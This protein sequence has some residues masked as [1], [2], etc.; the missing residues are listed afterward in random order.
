[1]EQAWQGAGA[2]SELDLV[3]W[4]DEIVGVLQD[5]EMLIA[6]DSLETMDTDACCFDIHKS[7][8]SAFRLV[9]ETEQP[10]VERAGKEMHPREM[11][12]EFA[13]ADLLMSAE[14]I[15]PNRETEK[16]N[17]LCVHKPLHIVHELLLMGDMLDDVAQ[18]D[19]VEFTQVFG[20]YLVYI[21]A[22][23]SHTVG[24]QVAGKKCFARIDFGLVDV[25]AH[26][27]AA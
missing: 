9:P 23:Q 17:R 21:V 19:D 7:V 3:V 13:A 12:E 8:D 24:V 5:A 26:T 18:D 27:F 4:I 16:H 6:Q 22:N 1:M 14:R 15:A 20:M 25:D 11:G 10:A 2:K